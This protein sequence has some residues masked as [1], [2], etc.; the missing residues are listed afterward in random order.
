MPAGWRPNDRHVEKAQELGVDLR[1][2]VELFKLH[3]ET[4]DRRVRNWNAAFTQW[5][6]KSRKIADE[7]VGQNGGGSSWDKLSGWNTRTV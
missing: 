6:I 2:Q 1:E 3:A 4:H 5:L 7:R